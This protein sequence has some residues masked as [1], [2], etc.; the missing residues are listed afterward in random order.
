[1]KNRILNSLAVPLLKY[2][3]K[4]NGLYLFNDKK[5]QVDFLEKIPSVNLKSKKPSKILIGSIRSQN[6]SLL[7]EGALGAAFKKNGFD[8]KLIQCG[9][10]LNAC[11]TKSHFK[12][13]QIYCSMCHE[14]FDYYKNA[15]GLESLKYSEI[16][17]K[18]LQ[19]NIRSFVNKIELS[20]FNEWNG[21]SL[22]NEFEC[23]IQR[24]Y[25]STQTFFKEKPTVA[26]EFLFTVIS[27]FEVGQQLFKQ[28]Y[29]HLISSHGIYSTW[30]GLVSGFRNAG[31]DV[32][33][34]GRGY[35]KSK[36]VNF[37]GESY[38]NGL[39]Y[40]DRNYF[41]NVINPNNRKE[42]IDY[43]NARWSL[44]NTSDLVTYYQKKDS[45]LSD[46]ELILSDDF[47]YVS[48]F[49]NIPWDGQAF[50]STKN[51]KSLNDVLDALIKFT[52]KN[53]NVKVIIRPHP[54]ENPKKNPHIG[55]TFLDIAKSY[56]LENNQQFIVLPYSSSLTS[57]D[58][59]EKVKANIL[60]AGSIGLELAAKGL[61]VIQMGKNVSSNK[62]IYFEPNDYQEFEIMLT[63]LLNDEGNFNTEIQK[64]AYEWA[65]FYYS[66]AHVEDPFFE[67][68]GYQMVKVKDEID[69][70]KLAKYMDWVLN[71]EKL[72]Y[73]E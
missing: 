53:K 41:L 26:R 5:A 20:D 67:Y 44:T 25:L 29:T 32:T 45:N 61:N 31:G 68:K 54:A 28:G 38:L 30:G 35:Y 16:L 65:T 10:Y 1:M 58:I 46:K 15:F 23:G 37:K 24:F 9:Q 11:E 14:E 6:H 59:A 4:K 56:K 34:W 71:G 50:V 33:V 51:F 52:N 18:D 2:R 66:Q 36:I 17:P 60:F 43:L 63:K 27:S 8:V 64:K 19:D 57:Y 49:P 73:E 13:S 39:K 22:R 72:F 48:F 42:V 62:E 47:Q 21:V 69:R 55:E 12:D 70:W 7:F 3:W 40:I